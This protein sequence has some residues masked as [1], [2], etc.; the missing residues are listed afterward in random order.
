MPEN[1]ASAEFSQNKDAFEETTMSATGSAFKK[2]SP[3][4]KRPNKGKKTGPPR[5]KKTKA[6]ELL[7]SPLLT[8]QVLLF[9]IFL[10]R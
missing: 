3:K 5:G 1:S 8:S 10:R 7:A 9:F 4:K 2:T 6:V